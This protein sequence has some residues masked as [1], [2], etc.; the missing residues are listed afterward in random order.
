M[1]IS[2]AVQELNQEIARLI[3]IRDSL[4]QA[5]SPRAGR[6]KPGSPGPQT[7][8][9]PSTKTKTRKGHKMSAEAK[10]RIGA[11]VR[12]RWAAKKKAEAK[13]AK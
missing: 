9:K 2:G 6:K 4:V 13:A 10:K 3:A 7:S 1:S 8:P 12:A 11:A 5:S